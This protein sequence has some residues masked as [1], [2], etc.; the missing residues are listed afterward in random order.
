MIKRAKTVMVE[1]IV[2][3]DCTISVKAVKTDLLKELVHT[4]IEYVDGWRVFYRAEDK[5]LVIG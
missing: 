1:V 5:L 4:N 2:N 3:E